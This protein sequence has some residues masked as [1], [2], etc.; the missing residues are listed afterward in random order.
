MQTYRLIV[1]FVLV[2]MLWGTASVADAQEDELEL[3]TNAVADLPA[4]S[5][6]GNG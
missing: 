5:T 6:F 3:G 1:T 4:T 2:G